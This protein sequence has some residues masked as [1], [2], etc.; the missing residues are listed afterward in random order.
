MPSS[1]AGVGGGQNRC[2]VQQGP[3]ALSW[4]AVLSPFP[5]K[6]TVVPD[7]CMQA[8]W[9]SLS[10]AWSM[11]ARLHLCQLPKWR[12]KSTTQCILPQTQP[13]HLSCLTK[14]SV[15]TGQLVSTSKW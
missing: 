8:L 12:K 3:R 5:G 6:S 4:V 7:I 15:P 13:R 10:P 2:G 11:M 9:P 1:E 14:A